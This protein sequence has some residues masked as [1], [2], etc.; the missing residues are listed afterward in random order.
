MKKTKVLGTGMGR[1]AS[2]QLGQQGPGRG[3]FVTQAEGQRPRHSMACLWRRRADKVQPSEEYYLY[4]QTRRWCKSRGKENSFFDLPQMNQLRRVFNILDKD[5]SGSISPEELFVPSISLGLVKNMNEIKQLIN[6]VDENFNGQIEFFEFLKIIK[7]S[8]RKSE[9]GKLDEFFKNLLTKESQKHFK[10]S[11]S[12]FFSKIRR[13]RLMDVIR[14]E[15]ERST[16]IFESVRMFRNI[17]ELRN[18]R[19]TGRRKC[20]LVHR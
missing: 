20:V 8:Q 17:S 19:R 9:L 10:H 11:F 14:T 13:D 12:L 18:L 6:M 1:S 5:G 2:C 7:I 3:K 16:A 4:D 15:K